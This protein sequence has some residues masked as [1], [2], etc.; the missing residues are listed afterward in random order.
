M[1][2]T[3]VAAHARVGR[4]TTLTYIRGLTAAGILSVSA[5]PP[6]QAAVY[7]LERDTGVR[8]PRVRRDGGPVTQGLARDRM[9]ATAKIL[10]SFS[11]RDLALAASTEDFAVSEADAKS[12][13]HYLHKGGYLA[14]VSAAGRHVQATY[15]FLRSADSGPQPPQVQRVRQVWDPNLQKVVWSEDGGGRDA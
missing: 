10:G 6:G 2:V 8:T 4:A 15:R 7:T 12:Y 3:Q 13:V 5:P 9:W 11:A 14:L 1:T